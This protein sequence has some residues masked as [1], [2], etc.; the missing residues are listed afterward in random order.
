ML[1]T[2]LQQ[3]LSNTVD[4]FLIFSI[5]QALPWTILVVLPTQSFLVRHL[6]KSCLIIFWDSDRLYGC[7]TRLSH[8]DVYCIRRIKTAQ[9]SGPLRPRRGPPRWLNISSCQ[10][11]DNLD[12]WSLNLIQQKR[13]HSYNK[14]MAF[15]TLGAFLQIRSREPRK[16]DV[17]RQMWWQ[18]RCDG[19]KDG[20][21]VMAWWHYVDGSRMAWWW[22]QNEGHLDTNLAP[23]VWSMMDR[24]YVR[25]NCRTSAPLL[26]TLWTLVLLSMGPSVV[27]YP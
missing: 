11:H 16:D 7:N 3:G 8:C 27:K 5:C 21:G 14:I 9:L 24:A 10:I 4:Q 20:R 23:S 19:S 26:F 6:I 25:L 15:H 18:Q 1:F 13:V 12:V 22:L 17:W 2:N